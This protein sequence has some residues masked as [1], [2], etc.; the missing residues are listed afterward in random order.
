MNSD[1]HREIQE[2]IDL[3]RG[4]FDELNSGIRLPHSLDADVLREQLNHVVPFPT[5]T[6]R[7]RHWRA[8]VSVAACFVLVMGASVMRLRQGGDTMSRAAATSQSADTAASTAEAAMFEASV[9]SDVDAGIAR[10]SALPDDT[11]DGADTAA[12]KAMP[13]A[14]GAPLLAAE[15]PTD[16]V[17]EA[18]DTPVVG[19]GR[20]AEFVDSDTLIG[21]LIPLMEL[22]DARAVQTF[23]AYVPVQAPAGMVYSSGTK[24][25]SGVSVLFLQPGGSKE[26]QM[27][28]STLT[29]A[30]KA[31]VVDPSR[32]ETY[33]M[34][35]YSEPYAD[36]IP[37]NL[38]EICR[39]ATF[40]ADDVTEQLLQARL[41]PDSEPGDE[42][43]YYGH[44]GVL[45]GADIVVR[46]NVIDLS[47]QEL[48]NMIDTTRKA[49][50]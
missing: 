31:Y 3:L 16:L 7:K 22:S 20:A 29:E 1:M 43:D 32:P 12:P 23:G 45:Y 19:A 6:S 42:K 49:A 11:A 38:A 18:D 13:A 40:S 9:S 33:D 15:T 10:F 34:R 4:Q 26:L 41:L 17:E 47:P 44:V 37:E 30:E 14:E 46:Y 36:S 28:V 50:E 21:D 39:N 35:L 25:E 24:S 27:S 5:S 2:S 8:G 48:Y